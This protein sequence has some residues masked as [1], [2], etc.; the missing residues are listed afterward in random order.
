MV[1]IEVKFPKL[2]S[3]PPRFATFIF[4]ENG[5]LI[6]VQNKRINKTKESPTKSLTYIL[7]MLVPVQV[8]PCQT[9][10]QGSPPFGIHPGRLGDPSETYSPFIAVTTHHKKDIKKKP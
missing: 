1:V 3:C 6:R 5:N 7:V 9:S 4:L 2:L 10:P 8:I